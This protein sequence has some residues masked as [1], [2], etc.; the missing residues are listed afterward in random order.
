MKTLVLLLLACVVF[1]EAARIPG[2]EECMDAAPEEQCKKQKA[3]KG[4]CTRDAILKEYCKK[5]CGLCGKCYDGDVKG[6][7]PEIKENGYCDDGPGI[8]PAYARMFCKK[9][10]GLCFKCNDD[11]T[12]RDCPKCAAKGEC[13]FDPFVRAW[14]KKS[15]GFCS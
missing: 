2:K 6:R 9:T 1:S 12:E 10:C 5:T 15:C 13:S 7:C 4:G 14:C 3:K 8:W 11:T